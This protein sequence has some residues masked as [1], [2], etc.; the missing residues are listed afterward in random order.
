LLCLGRHTVTG[1][2]TTAGRQFVDWS[3][4][5]RLFEHTRFEPEALFDV[6]REAVLQELDD[7]EPLVAMLDDTI[8]RKT[9]TKI[10]GASWRRDP[11]GPPFQTNIV[12]GQRFLQLSAALPE[13][14]G[15]SRARA[16][17]IDLL[18]C[19]TP[20]KP[21]KTASAETWQEY[22]R[23]SEKMKISR[24]GAERIR[25]LR[26]KMDRTPDASQR[27]LVVTGD[28]GYTNKTVLRELPERASYI[29]RIRKDAKLF[30]LPKAEPETQKAGRRRSYGE[31]LPTPEEI[32]RDKS[33]PWKTVK[34]YAAGKVH[35]FN[36]KTM[37]PVRWKAA[38]GQT[39]L[40]L[41]VIRPLGYRLRKGGKILYRS[42]SYLICTDVDYP[43]DTLVQ[44]YIW[45]WEIEVNFRDEKTLLGVGQAQVRTKEAAKNFPSFIIAAYAF[46]LLAMW[47][48]YGSKPDAFP[49]P[50]WRKKDKQ[51]RL[52]TAQ[53]IGL[54]RVQ[55]WAQALGLNNFSSFVSHCKQEPKPLKFQNQLQSAVCHAIN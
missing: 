41:V 5:Y 50:K 48:A 21:K 36:I 53:G 44:N 40:R 47:R 23:Q 19:P 46:L 27:K 3:A 1:L 52:S 33:I 30:A 20:G 32:L 4:D 8:L 39:D 37:A 12:W 55:V 26:E 31:R 49:L 15:P 51:R 38:G 24:R 10:S 6:S 17:P 29:G 11:L 54:L 25:A 18:H 35:E 28:G 42:P 14:S 34:A 7:Q 22:A 13:T 16:I 9:G 45:R 43:V 2:V